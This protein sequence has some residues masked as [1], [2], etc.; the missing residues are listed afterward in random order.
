MLRPGPKRRAEY[1]E[2]S[3]LNPGITLLDLASRSAEAAHRSSTA[4][5][6]S[7]H[8][9]EPDVIAIGGTHAEGEA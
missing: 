1:V 5:S 6:S 9:P 3:L 8:H 2:L 7:G 4:V